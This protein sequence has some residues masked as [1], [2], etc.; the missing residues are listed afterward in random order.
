MFTTPYRVKGITHKMKGP[1][2]MKAPP[3]LYDQTSIEAKSSCSSK[4]SLL[5]TVSSS[6][7]GGNGI[8]SDP[9][10]IYSEVHW[11]NQTHSQTDC[12]TCSPYG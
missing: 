3:K 8:R 7:N 5:F 11:T 2:T 1:A 4:I 6:N 9:T 10:N 12:I